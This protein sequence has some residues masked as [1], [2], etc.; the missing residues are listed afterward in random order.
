MLQRIVKMAGVLWHAL[1]TLRA[2]TRDVG[3]KVNSRNSS[4]EVT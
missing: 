4:R 2:L 3:G 1:V